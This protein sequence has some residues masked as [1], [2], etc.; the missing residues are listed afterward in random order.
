MI[1]YFRKEK[2][3]PYLVGGLI[4]C[5]LTALVAFNHTIGA[6]TAIARVAALI[7]NGLNSAHVKKTPYFSKLLGDGVVFN[8]SVVFIIGVFLGAFISSKLVLNKSIRG[9]TLWVHAF[10]KSKIVRHVGAFIGGFL[11]LFGAR[12]ANGCTSGHAISGGAQLSITSFVFMLTL[13]AVGI[14]VS[15]LLYKRRVL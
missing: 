13:F 8:W 12:V 10:G 2:W 4:G 1:R 11:L 7:E 6:S 15:H 9:E 5:L 14:P 3:S